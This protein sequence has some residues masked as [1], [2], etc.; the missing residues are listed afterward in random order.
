VRIGGARL[1]LL[2]EEQVRGRA[3]DGVVD[4]RRRLR[5]LAA[6]QDG[7]VGGAR[8][9]AGEVDV[10][11]DGAEHDAQEAEHED[12]DDAARDERLAPPVRPAAA[13]RRRRRRRRPAL[14]PYRHLTASTAPS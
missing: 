6:V 13:R 8:V 2:E 14:R 12:G 9:D 7:A 10:R 3:L 5:V 1:R 11:I 4:G